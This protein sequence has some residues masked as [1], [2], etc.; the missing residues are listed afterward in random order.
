MGIINGNEYAW[1]IDFVSFMPIGI[2]F[3][4]IFE[5]ECD[6]ANFVCGGYDIVGYRV[7]FF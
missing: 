3:S 6:A 1:A 4:W 2:E 5:Q 7:S